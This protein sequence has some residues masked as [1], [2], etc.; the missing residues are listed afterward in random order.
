MNWSNLGSPST[1]SAYPQNR[2]AFVTINKTRLGSDNTPIYMRPQPNWRIGLD[3]LVPARLFNDAAVTLR[4][5]EDFA[6][7]SSR[8][9]LQQDWRFAAHA[10]STPERPWNRRSAS[11]RDGKERV[12]NALAG[13]E[14]HLEMLLFLVL[15]RRPHRPLLQ[16]CNRA[17]AHPR[18]GVS[19]SKL[20]RVNFLHLALHAFRCE[21]AVLDAELFHRAQHVALL[22]NIALLH[23]RLEVP[24]LAPVERHHGNSARNEI[25]GLGLNLIQR[26]LDAVKHS[27][28]QTRPQL[29][30][31]GRARAVH[32]L[33]GLQAARVLVHLNGRAV[34]LQRYYLAGKLQ[35][36]D[37]HELVDLRALHSLR[38]YDGTRNL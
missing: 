3:Q 21:N 2:I 24:L 32:L 15:A 26:P 4:F 6:D 36:P 11:L 22:H 10:L 17:A 33:A 18:N 34:A 29:H 25:A 30:G 12:D 20:A 19:N 5:L 27:A 35:L 23:G 31:K 38:L 14:R 7:W 8:T 28:Q 37:F 13:H 16:H 1:R 9:V